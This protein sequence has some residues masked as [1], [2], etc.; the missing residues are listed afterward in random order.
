MTSAMSRRVAELRRRLRAEQL[1]AKRLEA[2]GKIEARRKQDAGKLAAERQEE[3]RKIAEGILEISDV[4][5]VQCLKNEKSRAEERVRIAAERL[6]AVKLFGAS[7]LEVDRLRAEWI[8][9]EQIKTERLQAE[10]D[11]VSRLKARELMG[12]FRRVHRHQFHAMHLINA[13]DKEF[14]E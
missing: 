6:D 5:A 12:E 10:L 1:E 9:A 14:F 4:L 2:H 11:A 8:A 13:L 7:H 3:D